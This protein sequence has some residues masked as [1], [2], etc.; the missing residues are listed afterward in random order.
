MF[1]NFTDPGSM[2]PDQ[3]QLAAQ[4]QLLIAAAIF[5]FLLFFR[6]AERHASSKKADK[7]SRLVDEEFAAEHESKHPA[8]S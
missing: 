4:N 8:R 3:L 7:I 6:A 5:L 2:S 1:S